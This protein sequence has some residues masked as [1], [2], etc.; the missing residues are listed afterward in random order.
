MEGRVKLP[1][2]SMEGNR[3]AEKAARELGEG[4][5]PR[6]TRVLG[7]IR[8]ILVQWHELLKE[9]QN[10]NGNGPEFYLGGSPSERKVP[11]MRIGGLPRFW[12]IKASSHGMR[13][14]IELAYNETYKE[15]DYPL[16]EYTL[17]YNTSKDTP[18][19]NVHISTVYF[20]VEAQ[21]LR[22]N[23]DPM[24]AAEDYEETEDGFGQGDY[25]HPPVFDAVWIAVW[26][27]T[28]LNAVS[29]TFEVTLDNASGKPALYSE[30][31]E[32]I[33]IDGW[34]LNEI[35]RDHEQ[36]TYIW[37]AAESGAMAGGDA[38]AGA[39]MPMYNTW[40]KW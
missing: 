12:S 26:L 32:G 36:E 14:K 4:D 6:F 17:T 11:T 15:K 31:M 16:F 18:T 28:T 1:A 34:R 39:K 24:Q 35:V 25:S 27:G 30:K 3:I 13:R 37:T 33:R 40:L 21:A 5:K 10:L 9:P 20:D 23:M 29:E 8:D 7:A 38:A 2:Q 22:A 19:W